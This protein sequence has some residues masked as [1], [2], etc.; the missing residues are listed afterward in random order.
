MSFVT[1]KV[2]IEVG[3]IVK[4]LVKEVAKFLIL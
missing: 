2:H 4:N 3:K 1:K